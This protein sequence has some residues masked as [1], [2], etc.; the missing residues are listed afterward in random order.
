MTDEPLQHWLESIGWRPMRYSGRGMYG[1]SCLGVQL[2]TVG[3]LFVLGYQL[4]EGTSNPTYI[5]HAPKLDNLGHG[6]I[7]YWPDVAWITEEEQADG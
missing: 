4:G 3:Q 1:K 6:V 2:D 7:A 5:P